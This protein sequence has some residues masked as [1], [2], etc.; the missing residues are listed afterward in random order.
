M[1]L[2]QTIS[3][4]TALGIGVNLVIGLPKNEPTNVYIIVGLIGVI[5]FAF[6]AGLVQGL[7]TRP[8]AAARPR[9]VGPRAAQPLAPSSD[10]ASKV[11]PRGQRPNGRA[12]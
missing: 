11:R 4:A 3:L 8:Q 1:R 12:F 2:L 10:P 5:L 9:D 7:S 6:L